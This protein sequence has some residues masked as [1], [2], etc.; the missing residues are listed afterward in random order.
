VCYTLQWRNQLAAVNCRSTAVRVPAD[1]VRSMSQVVILICAS[2]ISDNNTD[3]L[4]LVDITQ[5]IF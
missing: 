1:D 3:V 2:H 5:N 4:A